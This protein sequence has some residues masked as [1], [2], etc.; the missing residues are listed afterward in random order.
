[1]KIERCAIVFAT[2]HV[3]AL[4]PIQSSISGQ[5]TVTPRPGHATVIAWADRRQRSTIRPLGGKPAPV[6]Q[7]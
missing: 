4:V 1:V 6:A 3:T 5:V 7:R 2:F